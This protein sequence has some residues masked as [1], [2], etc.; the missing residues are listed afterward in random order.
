MSASVTGLRGAQY[1]SVLYIYIYIYSPVS[2]IGCH[3]IGQIQ[4]V[5]IE[6]GV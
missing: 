3:S 5:R 1:L 6:I 2:N 4:I